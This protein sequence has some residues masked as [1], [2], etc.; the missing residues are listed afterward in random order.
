[1]RISEYNGRRRFV[2]DSRPFFGVEMCIWIWRNF[3]VSEGVRASL[4]SAESL[5]MVGK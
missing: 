1:M 5:L 4:S 3:A 2:Y